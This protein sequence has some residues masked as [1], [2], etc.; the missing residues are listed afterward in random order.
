[1]KQPKN[2]VQ[3]DQKWLGSQ[4]SAELQ[5]QSLKMTFKEAYPL[6]SW[7]S[8]W[9]QAQDGECAPLEGS[10][11]NAQSQGQPSS[12]GT[13][14]G[15]SVGLLQTILWPKKPTKRWSNQHHSWF[16]TI[17]ESYIRKPYG[18][19]CCLETFIFI[20]GILSR[21]NTRF[22]VQCFKTYITSGRQVS[23]TSLVIFRLYFSF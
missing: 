9:P 2:G 8:Q 17:I 6:P 4:T 14:V 15:G 5:K 20:K 21:V 7:E 23:N 12:R 3:L 11:A 1:M 19:P 10:T 16:Y 13:A 18:L 22:Q